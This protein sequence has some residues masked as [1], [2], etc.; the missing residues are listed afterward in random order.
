MSSP[1]VSAPGSAQERL[2]LLHERFH[3]RLPERLAA[4]RGAVDAAASGGSLEEPARLF[5]QI[6]GTAGT[7]GLAAITPVAREGEELCTGAI[8]PRERFAALYRVL[9]ELHAAAGGRTPW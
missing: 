2:L 3:R 5:H 8:G 1:P 6:A 7:Y 4:I 9:G